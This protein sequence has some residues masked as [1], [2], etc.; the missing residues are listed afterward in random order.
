VR[1]RARSGAEATA[2]CGS[3]ELLVRYTAG[4]RYGGRDPEYGGD[5]WVRPSVKRLVEHYSG[6]T[7]TDFSNM[8][9]GPFPPHASHAA[10]VDVDVWF[11]GYNTRGSAV[12]ERIV[13]FL[14]DPSYGSSIAIVGV[15]HTREFAR[16]IAG[17]KLADGRRATDAIQNW[18]GHADHCHWR[19][20]APVP[21]PGTG[22][23]AAQP[24]RRRASR[25]RSGSGGP[26][27]MAL[28]GDGAPPTGLAS[29]LE[30]ILM[31]AGER[32]EPAGEPAHVSVAA[33]E[34]PGTV[35]LI[36]SEAS[37][38]VHFLSDCPALGQATHET[39]EE[40]SDADGPVA[41]ARGYG[42]PPCG[43]CL[44]ML[45]VPVPA[46]S[47]LGDYL[48]WGEGDSE[49]LTVFAERIEH[50]RKA[51]W[52]TPE[53]VTSHRWEDVLTIEAKGPHLL[54]APRVVI[55]VADERIDLS[56]EEETARD[57]LYEIALGQ[58]Q[59]FV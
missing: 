38:V 6:I 46:E 56:F 36:Q 13:E 52:R 21:Q 57:E 11:P 51:T 58:F 15:T 40:R 3:V 30:A 9:G 12:A 19:I 37:A 53:R 29:V 25:S 43:T 16:A 33:R 10:G 42:S 41:A 28:A 45:A 8:N 14:N 50:V 47:T 44:R 49:E 4:N 48:W 34:W 27:A 35:F 32:D 39:V 31:R 17:V 23:R 26:R 5:D 55:V 54:S 1:A 2:A 24:R 59:R 18:K 20:S 22:P 7:L